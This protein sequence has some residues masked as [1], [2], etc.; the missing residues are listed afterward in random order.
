MRK[1]MM[2]ELMRAKP[3]A[4]LITVPGR[5]KFLM[6]MRAIVTMA[7]MVRLERNVGSASPVCVRMELVWG[8]VRRA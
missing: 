2:P 7:N 4:R 3:D 8:F 6:I 5:L 1:N